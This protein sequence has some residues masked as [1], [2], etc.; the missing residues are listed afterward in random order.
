MV[1]RFIAQGWV[2][3]LRIDRAD[4]DAMNLLGTAYLA[5]GKPKDAVDVL[6]RAVAFVPT[7]WCEPYAGLTTAYTSL[8]DAAGAGYAGGMVAFCEGRPDEAKAKLQPLTNGAVAVDAM[9]GLALIAAAEGD[10]DTATTLYTKVL[11][12]DPEN[13]SAITGL[14]GLAT[15]DHGATPAPSAPAASPSAAVK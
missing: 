12:K 5:N 6:R 15:S 13:F 11:E 4:A 14:K 9:L 7:G 8:G 3:A 1:L 10:I 2:T